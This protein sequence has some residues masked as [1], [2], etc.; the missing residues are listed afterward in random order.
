MDP[1]HDAWGEHVVPHQTRQPYRTLLATPLPAS[2]SVRNQESSMHILERLYSKASL[3]VVVVGAAVALVLNP[4]LHRPAS[5]AYDFTKE[6]LFIALKEFDPKAAETF[7]Q[8]LREKVRA[9][10]WEHET[11]SALAALGE[12]LRPGA[13][14][15][16]SGTALAT[17]A[18][19]QLAMLSEYSQNT[20][21]RFSTSAR[22]S[23]ACLR[24]P[25]STSLTISTVATD[26]GVGTPTVL[27]WATTWPFM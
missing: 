26:T 20:P 12:E 21:A 15:R 9:G 19:A 2:V 24:R 5:S 4:I 10:K 25:A 11:A 14:S 27:P 13:V 8:R 16:T 23:G 17:L 22:F 1:R 3:K 7:A 18:R 6:P